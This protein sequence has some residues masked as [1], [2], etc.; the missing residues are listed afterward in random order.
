MVQHAVRPLVPVPDRHHSA[1]RQRELFL[2]HLRGRT[3]RSP[4]PPP[5]CHGTFSFL[6]WRNS[7]QARPHPLLMLSN[8]LSQ[9]HSRCILASAIHQ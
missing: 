7:T 6:R 9:G 1:P 3:S 5:P 8:L 4:A 2:V